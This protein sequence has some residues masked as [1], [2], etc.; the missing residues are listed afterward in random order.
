MIN[1]NIPDIMTLRVTCKLM[2]TFPSLS[3]MMNLKELFYKCLN[4]VEIH[5]DIGKISGDL[6]LIHNQRIADTG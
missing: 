2:K 1:E 6:K 5:R 4:I 3:N